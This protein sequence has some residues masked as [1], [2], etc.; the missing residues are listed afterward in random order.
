MLVESRFDADNPA[1]GLEIELNIID[2][3]GQPGD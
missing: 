2:E 1:T 3:D